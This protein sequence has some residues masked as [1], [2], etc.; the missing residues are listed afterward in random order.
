RQGEGMGSRVPFSLSLGLLVSL[1]LIAATLAWG[2]TRVQYSS[3]RRLWLFREFGQATLTAL[4]PN[5]AVIAHWEQGMTLQYLRLVEGQRP[6]VWIDVLEPSDEAWGARAARR[7]A[8]RP[9]FF[10]GSAADVAGLPAE[11][12]RENDYADLFQLRR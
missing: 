10:V 8:D 2:Y 5:A 6:D 7:Y 1:A 4:P 11:L 12:V 3:K 9:V